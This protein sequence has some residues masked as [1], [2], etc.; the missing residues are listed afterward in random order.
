[1]SRNYIGTISQR[2]N[3]HDEKQAFACFSCGMCELEKTA[4]VIP[5]LMGQFTDNR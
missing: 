3:R 4:R 5:T 2:F 1:M